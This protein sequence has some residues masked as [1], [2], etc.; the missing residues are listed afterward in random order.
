MSLH[1]GLPFGKNA[2]FVQSLITFSITLFISWVTIVSSNAQTEV[3]GATA[4]TVGVTPAG[5][6]SYSIPI[7][8]P[9]G[10]TGVQ[11]KLALQ[12]NSQ[13]GNGLVGMGFSVLGLSTISRCPTDN[14]YDNPA[15]G[16]IGIDPVDYDNNDKYCLNG[17]RLV[18]VNG[19][20]GADGTEYRTILE[21][22]DKIISYGN[23]AGAPTSFTVYKKSGEIFTYGT[24]TDSRVIGSNQTQV[25]TWALK[26][27]S[28]VKGNYVEFS[29]FNDK[30]TGQF[31][32]TKV[33][34]TGNDA[35]GLAPYNRVDFIYENRP[36]PIIAYMTRR[37]G[38]RLPN[39][40]KR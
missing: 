34:Y 21:S 30:P 25:G 29:Y 18:S 17:Q 12:Y 20:Y 28:D 16:G 31:Y 38:L 4:G 22:F 8:V 24:S 2:S 27:I 40:S 32:L 11:P 6:A 5:G 19:T 7:A 35:L 23:T 37:P 36:E 3:V 1:L 39:A 9:V 14:F 10:T 33:D 15:N 13:A 26:R